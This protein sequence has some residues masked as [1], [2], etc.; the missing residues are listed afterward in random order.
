MQEAI[1]TTLM[2]KDIKKVLLGWIESEIHEGKES[3]ACP[4][5]ME[6]VGKLV[7]MVKD[8]SEAEKCCMEK[9]Y[10]EVMTCLALEEDGDPELN[11]RMGYDHWRYADGKYAP[12]GR[13]H[14]SGYTPQHISPRAIDMIPESM[15]DSMVNPHMVRMGYDSGDRENMSHS[16]GRG[17]D[18]YG[19]SEPNRSHMGHDWPEYDGRGT[20]IYGQ[21]Y[22]N[23]KSAK[24][25]Y[26]E[27]G[28]TT[29]KG[30]MHHQEMNRSIEK[31]ATHTAEALMEMWEDAD[32]ETRQ[33]VEKSVTKL[34]TEMKIR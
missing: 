23:Y 12:K 27:A 1:A 26:H 24:R 22:D 25:H 31:A 10:Y 28:G 33:K 5:A 14:R 32:P 17:S 29:E 18:E 34:A 15:R 3:M 9:K 11:T 21:D 6:G 19:A 20:S 13:G 7:D 4:E 2:I 16:G 30:K 8:L